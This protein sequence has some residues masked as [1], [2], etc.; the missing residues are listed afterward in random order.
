[1]RRRPLAYICLIYIVV[2]GVCT[3]LRPPDLNYYE[4]ADN[5]ECEALGKLYKIES[6]NN[7]GKEQFIFYL[8]QISYFEVIEEHL[9]EHLIDNPNLLH[10]NIKPEGLV[11]YCYSAEVEEIPPIGSKVIIR[12]E[13]SEYAQATNPGEFDARIYYLTQGISGKMQNASIVNISNEYN[14]F[15]DAGYKLR[16]YLEDKIK[17]IYPDKEAGILITMLLG[18]DS[19]LDREVKGLYRVGGILHILSVSGLHISVLGYGVYSLLRKMGVSVRIAVC[20]SIVWMWFYGIMIGMGVSAFRA[21][22]MFSLR[23]AALWWG[24]TYD[25]LTALAVAAAVLIGSEPMFLYHSGFWMSFSCVLAI[26]LLYPHLKIEKN[27]N[28]SAVQ[29]LGVKIYNSFLISASVTIVTLPVMLW[30]YYEISLWGLLL[31]LIVVPLTSVVMGGGITNLCIPKWAGPMSQFIA[32]GNCIVLNF[33]ESLCRI[34]EWTEMGTVILGK[35][36]LWQIIFFV[37]GLVIFISKAKKMKYY[38]KV[39]ILVILIFILTIRMPQNFTI[40]FLDVGQGD[41][42]CIQNSNGNVYLIDGGSSS[43][44]NV[45]KYQILPFVKHEGISSISAVFLSHGDED[46][47]S[48]IEELLGAQKGGVRIEKVILPSLREEVLQKEFDT[49]IKLCHENDTEIYVMGKGESLIDGE[50]VLTG[51]HPERQYEEVSAGVAKESSKQLYKTSSNELS[52]VLHLNYKSFS[53][54]LTG[55]VEDRGEQ[56]LTDFLIEKDIADVTILKVAHHGSSGSSSKKF[57]VQVSPQ[58]AVISCGENNRYGHPH[59]ET[60]ERLSDCGAAILTTPEWGAISVTVNHKG[61]LLVRGYK[62]RE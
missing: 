4:Y 25:L 52:L 3:W 22:V 35:A 19:N 55:D 20:I 36:K 56:T 54:L 10:K 21:V 44:S 46:H 58:V 53:M 17:Q 45:G 18:N 30:F 33:F 15:A 9:E 57:L 39:V 40:T 50:L 59:E 23:M 38:Q 31:N 5:R 27:D 51:L 42:I 48:G 6:Q 26:S 41:G 14:P 29:A 7:F 13:F 49:V 2:I 43:K 47:I 62:R 8:N 1:M 11:C 61:Q 34:S 24:R 32:Y 12:G 28:M 37:V 60:L 16:L